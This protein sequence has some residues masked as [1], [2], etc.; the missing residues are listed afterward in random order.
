MYFSIF[1]IKSQGVVNSIELVHEKIMKLQMM[2]ISV[3]F[4]W[5][6]FRR[7]GCQLY[8]TCTYAEKSGT[9]N[10]VLAM[11]TLTSF[12]KYA[13]FKNHKTKFFFREEIQDLNTAITDRVNQE[14]WNLQDLVRFFL[15]SVTVV[16]R[17]RYQH[18]KSIWRKL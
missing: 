18:E 11:K 17:M 2:V 5:F 3:I 8:G 6:L 12:E 10:N 13:V 14:N 4:G 16:E 7:K 9:L 1:Y 15:K